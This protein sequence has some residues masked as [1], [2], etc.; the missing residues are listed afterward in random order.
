MPDAKK[1]ILAVD[2]MSLNLRTIKIILEKY[3]DVRVAKSGEQALSVL[4]RGRVNL[5]LLDI[6]MPGMSGFET[7]ELIRLQPNAENVPI[8][9][10]TSHVS[11]ELIAKALKKGA[12]DYIMKPFEPEVLIRKV[13]AAINGVSEKSVQLTWDGKCFILPSETP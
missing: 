2:D 12:R 13:Y 11:I 7:L 4:G 5:I 10:V 8:I 9:F 1:I 6:E 3:Y